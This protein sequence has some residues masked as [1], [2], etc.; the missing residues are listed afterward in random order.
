MESFPVA[1]RGYEIVRFLGSGGTA[2]VFL[3]R[4]LE[5]G[6]L[7]ALKFPLDSSPDHKSSFI[8]LIRREVDLIGGLRYPGL[9][10]IYELSNDLEKDPFLAMEPC[11]GKTLDSVGRIT[12]LRS[13]LNVL[14]S[15]SIDLYYLHQAGL[16]HGDLKPHNIF[17]S[18][19]ALSPECGKLSY[20]KI[21][22][23]SLARTIEEDS[24]QRLGM[25]TVGFMAPETI[26]SGELDSRSDIFAL[27]I[28][29]YLLTTG[30]H[31][32]SDKESDP[33]RIN[34]MIKEH[35]PQSPKN[36]AVNLP[37]GLSDLILSMLSKNPNGRP[38]D[39]YKIC[40]VLEQIGADFD[41]RHAIRPKHL[42]QLRRGFSNESIL[43]DEPFSLDDSIRARIIDY[44][45][46]NRDW[47]RNI[48]EINFS[49][50]YLRWEDGFIVARGK[51]EQI[52][53][54]RRLQKQIGIIF[55]SL[56]YSQRKKS[57]LAATIGDI[58]NAA[59]IGVINSIKDREYLTR[60]L[61]FMIR[62][63]LSRSSILRFS[64]ILGEKAVNHKGNNWLGAELFIQGKNLDR[65][66]SVGF[67]AANEAVN[68]NEI[69]RALGL[70]GELE[71]LCNEAK[72]NLRLATVLMKR[73]DILKQI[74]DVPSAEAIYQKI[75]K[76]Y[77]RL[78]H[79]KLLG[80]TYKDLGD[81]YKIKQDY[82]SGISA[83]E[84]AE[85]IYSEIGDQ[86][87]L[88]HT[89]NN[90]G[91]IYCVNNQFDKSCTYFRRALRTQ[92]RL[93]TIK[94]VASTLNNIGILYHLRGRRDRVVRILK[95]S[96]QFNR[97]LGNSLE[98]ARV[99]NNLG[100][101]YYEMG[102]FDEALS[103]LKE[104][105]EI[106]K[107]LG[108][109]LEL[110]F[111][112]ENL[113]QVMMDAGSLKEAI[114]YFKMGIDLSSGISD[115]PHYASF[116][117]NMAIALKR[118]GYYGKAS[119]NINKAIDIGNK[120]DDRRDLLVWWVAR[121]D[122]NF[123]LR[124][125]EQ[126]AEELRKA[127][128]LA[129][130]TSDKRAQLSICALI[131]LIEND[132]GSI[133]RAEGIARDL[134]SQRQSAVVNLKRAMLFLKSGDN[135][136]AQDTLKGLGDQFAGEKS[137]IE[138]SGYHNLLG[139]CQLGKDDIENARLNFEAALALAEKGSLL[140]E[141]VEAATN[142]GRIYV[143]LREFEAAY[144]SYKKAFKSLKI[145]VDDIDCE[146]DQTSFLSD[147]RIEIL[148]EEINRLRRA[149]GQKRKAGR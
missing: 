50:D 125:F 70:L 73:G 28:M 82:K 39:G 26:E 95:L 53:W 55:R 75:I 44:S 135:D 108:N 18:P 13:L 8:N 139:S 85:K 33:V 105:L 5:D 126:A 27:G 90:M 143:T 131:G 37:D 48:L 122:L 66:Y 137:D 1:P 67:D 100:S 146:S 110:L 58:D 6:R 17:L 57:V 109:H 74:G 24:S 92:R 32:F 40:E 20:S 124:R 87:E 80:E 118:M 25:G 60:P 83:L 69:S 116:M 101:S 148:T 103:S 115:M 35:E 89:L 29:A 120:F 98:I 104:S 129:E 68:R 65:G 19:V 31:P 76:L 61:L 9:V 2:R 93:N 86:L 106:N 130:E 21:S 4:R 52:I 47:L 136:K 63:N 94:D 145:M 30:V 36:L 138:S 23:F 64:N 112:Y 128:K 54:P 16:Y 147:G 11:F 113:A 142:L 99:L 121:G 79:D 38:V 62:Q 10:R 117:G 123:R 84:K 15:I 134:G 42:V 111:N 3:A 59:K 119:R 14:S 49:S 144:N 45:G 127:L 141:T 107:R 132:M 71:M 114:P 91:N 46:E 7:T 34:A 149:M 56:P 133:E 96:L 22:D 97:E 77:N 12:D 102:N 43:G 51:P 88:S 140:P 41:F 72:D 81:L 78:P